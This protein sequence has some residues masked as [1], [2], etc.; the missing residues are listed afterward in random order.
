MSYVK[1]SCRKY[2]PLYPPARICSPSGQNAH[3]RSL[4]SVTS[5]VRH[6]PVEALQ[7]FTMPSRATDTIR[8]PSRLTAHADTLSVCPCSVFLSTPLW[9]S[10]ILSVLSPDAETIQSPS[11]LIAQLFTTSS[12]PR[13]RR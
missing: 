5:V 10:H 2:S 11:G 6:S 3:V 12:C 4:P 7:I 13:R 9:T 8:D 1:T